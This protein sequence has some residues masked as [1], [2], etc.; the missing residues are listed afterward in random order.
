MNYRD[1]RNLSYEELLAY[2]K[3]QEEKVFR[4]H[5][6]F[7]WIYKKGAKNFEGMT[8]ISKGLVQKLKNDFSFLQCELL[9]QNDS[10][11]GTV[12]FLFK[13]EDNEKIETVVI[14]AVDRATVCVST[15]AGCKFRCAFCASGRGGFSRDLTC[16]EIV[17]QILYVKNHSPQPLSH[18]VFMGTGEPLDNYDNVMKAVRLINSKQGMNIAARHITIS[19]CGLIPEMLRLTQEDLQIELSVSLHG[20]NDEVRNI[21]MPVNKKYPLEDLIE[22]CREYIKRT[23]RQITFEYIL[24]KDL[25]CT[26]EAAQELGGL[27]RNMICKV[28]LI[29]CN[30]VDELRYQPPQKLEILFFKKKLTELGI[31]ATVRLPRGRDID[32]ACGQLRYAAG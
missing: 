16:A 7:D 11:D 17:S 6:I 8:N 9:K 10:L 23:N 31:H 13:L 3:T 18:V 25:T 12:K 26:A 32:A 1:I 5:Q 24:I 15:Q 4:A 28:N 20:S 14:P 29:P 19:T 30:P 27:L 21:L 2:L 22:A